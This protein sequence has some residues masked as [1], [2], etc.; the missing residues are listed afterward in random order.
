MF[1]NLEP[2]RQTDH[3]LRLQRKQKPGMKLKCCMPLLLLLLSSWCSHCL[4]HFN[5]RH[6]TGEATGCNTLVGF[7][8][9]IYFPIASGHSSFEKF[10]SYTLQGCLGPRLLSNWVGRYASCYALTQDVL[11]HRAL[12]VVASFLLSSEDCIR[13]LGQSRSSTLASLR[14][15][16]QRQS[17]PM[18]QLIGQ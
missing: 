13:S 15:K 4:N 8:G 10:I 14:A 16:P 1:Y 2:H 9:H 18:V 3:Q 11:Q 6:S 5:A 12:Y 17:W 7:D